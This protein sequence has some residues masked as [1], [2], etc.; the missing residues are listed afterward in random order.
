MKK[1]QKNK[2]DVIEDK[3]LFGYT[4]ANDAVEDYIS[5]RLL[6]EKELYLVAIQLGTTAIEK[7]F[8]SF[9]NFVHHEKVDER[10]HKPSELYSYDEAYF[11]H[12]N[13]EVNTDFLVWLDK[14]Y[15][16]R[17]S[18][19]LY[20]GKIISFGDRHFLFHLDFLFH[21]IFTLYTKMN[22]DLANLYFSN[23]RQKQIK[24]NN[25]LY[26]KLDRPT[27]LKQPQ[28]VVKAMFLGGR[29][30]DAI[31]DMYYYYPNNPFSFEDGVVNAG[32]LQVPIDFGT[33]TDVEYR[34]IG[35]KYWLKRKVMLVRDIFIHSPLLMRLFYNYRVRPLFGLQPQEIDPDELRIHFSEE[36]SRK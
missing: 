23:G 7:L 31:I 18:S 28:K 4:L 6:F 14:V 19:E 8:K 34:A 3:N 33:I 10:I 29:R 11:K 5:C 30:T 17:Y 35:R 1:K 27:W 9:I 16:S 26:S 20:P 15:I 32:A 36:I 25:Q 21:Q 22:E 13:I 24:K 12:H 2:K